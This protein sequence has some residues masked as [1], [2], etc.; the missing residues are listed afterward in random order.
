MLQ[1]NI[2]I[3]AAQ[4]TNEGLFASANAGTGGFIAWLVD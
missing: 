2:L 1:D 4:Q 3:P